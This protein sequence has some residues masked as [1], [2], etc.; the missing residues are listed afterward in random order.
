MSSSQRPL[1]TAGF[2]GEAGGVQREPRRELCDGLPQV[3]EL[4]GLERLACGASAPSSPARSSACPLGCERNGPSEEGRRELDLDPAAPSAG[5]RDTIEDEQ[6]VGGRRQARQRTPSPATLRCRPDPRREPRVPRARNAR[7][8]AVRRAREPPLAHP[9]RL[10]DREPRRERRAHA[11]ALDQPRNARAGRREHGASGRRRGGQLNRAEPELHGLRPGTAAAARRCSARS[12]SRT[13]QAALVIS[14]VAARR[15]T[16]G[17][18]LPACTAD[19][20][21]RA[22]NPRRRRATRSVRVAA[23]RLVQSASPPGDAM[24]PTFALVARR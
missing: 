12:E 14:L 17:R 22:F 1:N 6:P 5:R 16:G 19:P 21:A 15:R 23:G 20:A 4:L 10:P 18:A 9:D 8:I 13:S 24:A 2:W 3:V 7:L 11:D